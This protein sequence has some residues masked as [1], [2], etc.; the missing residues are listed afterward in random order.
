MRQEISAI[1]LGV[2]LAG[3][4]AVAPDAKAQGGP[5]GPGGAAASKPVVTSEQR[6][7]LTEKLR[8]VDQIARSV[9]PDMQANA[10]PAEGR[11]I[12][13]AGLDNRGLHDSRY[14]PRWRARATR[15]AHKHS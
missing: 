7:R 13:P 14:Q 3:T 10:I 11:I 4:V 6:A 1:A 9:D 5:S 15:H 8:L 12:D 2:L